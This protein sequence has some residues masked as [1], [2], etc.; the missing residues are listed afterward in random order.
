[1]LEVV[2]VVGIISLFQTP[3]KLF[4]LIGAYF[5][6]LYLV[7]QP[8][9]MWLGLRIREQPILLFL[10]IGVATIAVLSAWGITLE[11]S[12]NALVNKLLPR[13]RPANSS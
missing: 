11:K 1:M 6:G 10:L 13:V 3:A 12:T 5:Y 8:Y 9:V 7:H 2:G 4:G